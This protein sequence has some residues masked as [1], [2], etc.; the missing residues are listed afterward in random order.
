MSEPSPAQR[1]EPAAADAAPDAA[2]ADVWLL[3]D[4]LPR[5][6]ASAALTATTIEMAA[7]AADAPGRGGD[8]SPTHA[9]PW[10]WPAAVVVAALVAGAVAGRVT[11]PDPDRRLV[12]NL[13]VVRHLDLVREA[14]STTF[15]KEVAGRGGPPLRLLLRQGP[16]AARQDAS[17]FTA[18]VE[19]LGRLLRADT[20][21]RRALVATLGVEERA[22][23][24]RA[25]R[26]F[27]G[28]SGAERETL[29]AVAAALVD[30][31][32]PELRA[33]ALDWHRWLAVTRPE[34]R[35]DI[36]ASGTDK[37][38]DWIDWYAAR[39]EGRS[40]AAP[41]DRPPPGRRP[42]GG[43][44]PRGPDGRQRRPPP[45]GPGDGPPRP[46]FRPDGAP[47]PPETRAPP[48]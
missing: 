23:L 10:L 47:P 4:E 34:D 25:L 44:A 6:T 35:D 2:L 29:A 3:L 17:E 26:D 30:P 11:A 7:V 41:P 20:A 13:P 46:P 18:A 37:R 40:R 38:L 42:P 28:L 24:D 19:S 48:G 27:G 43:D 45:R 15:L 32:R 16:D 33:A 5:G 22:E 14:G 12:E 36:V 1:P 31:A 39:I 21:A 8:R 9:R